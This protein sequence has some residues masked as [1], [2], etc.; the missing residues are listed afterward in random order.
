MFLSVL[1]PQQ[2]EIKLVSTIKPTNAKKVQVIKRKIGNEMKLG[3]IK[4]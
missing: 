2:S 4:K 1:Q 3:E